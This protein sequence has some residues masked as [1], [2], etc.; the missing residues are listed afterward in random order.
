MPTAPVAS[1]TATCGFGLM[2][3]KDKKYTPVRAMVSNRRG[4]LSSM[5]EDAGAHVEE[6]F[7]GGN[8]GALGVLP[9]FVQAKAAADGNEA[10]G[11]KFT[12]AAHKNRASLGQTIKP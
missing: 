4:A 10:I 2:M 1:T 6:D 3:Q 5:E 7:G 8:S 9:P 11:A 12:R